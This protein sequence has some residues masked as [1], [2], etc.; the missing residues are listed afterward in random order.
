MMTTLNKLETSGARTNIQERQTVTVPAGR[1]IFGSTMALL[2]AS[3]T[4]KTTH[5]VVS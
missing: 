4:G 5:C 1:E 2:V 3:M